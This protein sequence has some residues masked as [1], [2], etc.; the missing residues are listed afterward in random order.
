MTSS[1]TDKVVAL[2][3]VG[4]REQATHIAEELIGRHLAACVNIVPAVRSIYRW[5]GKVWD[6]EEYLL[7]IK[8]TRARFD[9]LRDAIQSLHSYELPEVIAMPVSDGDAGVLDWI[10]RSVE[11]PASAPAAKG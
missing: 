2:T 7:V 10:A 4:S 1:L 9:A 3:T 11:P 5:K 6:D 8:S